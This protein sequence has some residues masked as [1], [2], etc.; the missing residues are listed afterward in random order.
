[1]NLSPDFPHQFLWFWL[2][3]FVFLIISG[4]YG[5]SFLGLVKHFIKAWKK[6]NQLKMWMCISAA[7]FAIMILL[8]GFFRRY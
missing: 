6:N 2:K 5:L 1:M 7:F 3:I 4:V 8:E